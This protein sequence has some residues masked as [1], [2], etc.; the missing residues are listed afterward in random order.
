[1]KELPKAIIGCAASDAVRRLV[2]AEGVFCSTAI[3]KA[4]V[5]ATAS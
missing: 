1:M 5:S 4:T 3:T 2:L